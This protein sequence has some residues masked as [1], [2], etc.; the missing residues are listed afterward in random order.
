MAPRRVRSAI[1]VAAGAGASL[2]FGALAVRDVDFD[3]FWRGIGEMQYLWLVPSLAALAVTVYLRAVR[4]QLLFAPE[5]RPPLP[6][7]T[8]ALLIGLLFN[9][10]LPLRAGEAARV[11]ALHQAA[12]TSKAEAAGTAVVERVYDVLT[13]LALLFVASPFLPS[14]SWIHGAAIFAAVFGAAVALA[15]VVLVV[16]G[17]RVLALFL[18]PLAALPGFSRVRTDAAAARLREGFRALH[19]APTALAAFFVTVAFWLVAALSYWAVLAGFDFRVGLGGALLAVVA[20]NLALVIPSLPAGLGVFEAA[21]V[22]ALAAY[23][24]GESRALACA[25]VLHAANF[26]P[27]LAAGLVA[28]HRHALER[29]RTRFRDQISPT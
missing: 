2:V 27:Y 1:G 9:Q 26:F 29:R 11:L 10:I 14:V 19:H 18:A 13:L 5:S 24:V 28:L 23:D 15:V 21:M 7:A 22:L 12:G 20:T 17:D 4:W 6:S 8:R 25:V 16:G 3:V